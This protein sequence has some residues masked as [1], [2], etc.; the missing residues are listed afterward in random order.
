MQ[1]EPDNKSSEMPPAH[2][3][4]QSIIR[5]GLFVFGMVMVAL[6]VIGVV[7][8]GLPTTVFLLAAIWAFS[9][10]SPKFERW[11]WEH[12]QL[13]PYLQNWYNHKIIP[14]KAKIMAISMMSTSIIVIAWLTESNIIP[15]VAVTA[16][17]IP[18]AI[19]I[20]TRASDRTDDQTTVPAA[21]S[22]G[23]K[24]VDA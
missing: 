5:W 6:G 15:F 7:V 4:S 23:T 14:I 2:V 24:K 1:V 18:T 21:D 12:P 9:R 11:L 10:S 16:M 20:C 17:L 8:P 3:A 22:H 13:G 19:Y